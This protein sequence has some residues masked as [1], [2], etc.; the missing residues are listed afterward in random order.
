MNN[1][2]V[3]FG[4]V[5]CNTTD[6]AVFEIS[7]MMCGITLM[8]VRRYAGTQMARMQ[9]GGSLTISC[10]RCSSRPVVSTETFRGPCTIAGER[11][12]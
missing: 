4:D 8:T 2:T 10:D 11:S 3:T 12:Q 9:I 6:E 1:T 7:C 5:P